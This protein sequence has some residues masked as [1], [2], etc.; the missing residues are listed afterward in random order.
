MADNQIDQDDQAEKEPEGKSANSSAE[1]Q[2]TEEKTV[3]YSRFQEVNSN[4]N[5][6][7]NELAALKAAE[8]KRQAD[9]EAAKKKQLEE[10]EKFKELYE[11][12]ESEKATAAEKL[13]LLN[14]KVES[15]TKALEA[16]WEAQKELIPELYRDLVGAMPIEQRIEWL[17]ANSEKLSEKEKGNGTPR[18]GASRRITQPTQD[19]GRRESAASTFRF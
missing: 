10:Q 11:A 13:E 9:S 1:T 8:E 19:Q 16:Q 12:S 6:M 2:N 14:V 17:S 15:M 7:K 18:G 3:P 5:A 4:F